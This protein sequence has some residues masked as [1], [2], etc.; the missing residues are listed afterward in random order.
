MT[1]N[2]NPPNVFMFIPN[3][4][5]YG[6]ALLIAAAFYY[7]KT[8]PI[9]FLILY[10]ISFA[11]DMFDG[12][13]ARY[14]RESSKFGA[15]LDMIIDRISTSGLLIVCSHF[16][17]QYSLIFIYLMMLDIG[18]HWLQTHSGF[19]D[20]NQLLNQNFMNE[21]HKSLEEKFWI[22]N[23]YYKNKYGLLFVCL[24][25]ELFLLQIF[26]LHF[27][28]ELLE[29]GCFKIFLYVNLA[30]YSLKQLISVIQI[31]SA[32][33]RIVRY[34]QKEIMIKKAINKHS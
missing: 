15:T 19:L 14:F 27:H 32:S 10:F 23:F 5:D 8:D 30:V 12:M 28:K 17:P 33:Q 34:D 29:V 7:A 13:A 18:S 26:Y 3:L 22:L 9:V 11:L 6:R 24:G 2:Q 21:N 1:S 4:M 20:P 31:V 16:Y 25:A